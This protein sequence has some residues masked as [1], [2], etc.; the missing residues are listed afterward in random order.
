M[1][2]NEDSIVEESSSDDSSSESEVDEEALIKYYLQRG[3]SYKEIPLL[4]NEKLRTKS[5]M[6]YRA[7]LARLKAYG[8]S[9]R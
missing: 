4:L 5:G 2:T 8:L 3:S 1:N 9:R 7:L 6:S